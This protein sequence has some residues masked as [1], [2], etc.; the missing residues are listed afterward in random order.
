M[1]SKDGIAARYILAFC[2]FF[3]SGSQLITGWPATLSGVLGTVEL[4]CALLCY[5]PLQNFIQELPPD[6]FLAKLMKKTGKN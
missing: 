3:L 6:V 5:S 2:F 1:L 4:T